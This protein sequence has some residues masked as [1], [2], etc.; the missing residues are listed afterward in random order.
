MFERNLKVPQVVG[1]SNGSLILRVGS[2]SRKGHTHLLEYNETTEMCTCEGAGWI[3]RKG[4]KGVKFCRHHRKTTVPTTEIPFEALQE[5]TRLMRRKAPL[6]VVMSYVTCQSPTNQ[7]KVHCTSCGLY[8]NVCNVHPIKMGRRKPLYWKFVTA[9]YNGRRKEAR[10][11]LREMTKE[12]LRWK[13][14]HT[15]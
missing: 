15:K 12:V 8:P 4:L 5:A 9:V 2:D 3:E 13:Q 7:G 10:V 14:N 6:R 1:Q 11:L